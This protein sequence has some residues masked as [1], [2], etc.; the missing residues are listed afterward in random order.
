MDVDGER[1]TSIPNK[2]Q[3][4]TRPSQQSKF[5]GVPSYNFLLCRQ[6]AKS[7]GFRFSIIGVPKVQQARSDIILTVTGIR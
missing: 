6:R 5:T 1:F 2:T 4:A 3:R 7:R